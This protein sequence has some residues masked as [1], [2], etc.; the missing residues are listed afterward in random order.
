MAWQRTENS[1]GEGG[2]FVLPNNQK[3]GS[4]VESK[5]GIRIED[6]GDY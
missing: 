3:M 2:A 1:W 6:S 5:F 4:I